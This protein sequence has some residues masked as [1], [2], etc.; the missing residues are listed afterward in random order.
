M[1]NSHFNNGIFVDLFEC[2]I[3][4]KTGK[5]YPTNSLDW[6]VDIEISDYIKKQQK[7]YNFIVLVNN[8]D[9]NKVFN[10]S[11]LDKIITLIQDF[12]CKVFDITVIMLDYNTKDKFLNYPNSGGFFNTANEYDIELWRSVYITNNSKEDAHKSCIPVL[13]NPFLI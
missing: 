7:S 6:K 11:K 2:L 12:L 1:Y 8:A 4:T 9:R 5:E 13:V 3:N 10:N